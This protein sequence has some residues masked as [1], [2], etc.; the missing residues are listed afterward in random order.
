MTYITIEERKVQR[1][2]TSEFL[3]ELIKDINSNKPYLEKKKLQEFDNIIKKDKNKCII[4]EQYSG[5]EFFNNQYG[6]NN[7]IISDLNYSNYYGHRTP[8]FF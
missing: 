3:K 7:V 1:K 6:A 5:C 4:N 8:S 2:E